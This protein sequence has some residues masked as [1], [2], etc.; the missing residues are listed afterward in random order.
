MEWT[1]PIEMPGVWL[2]A[3]VGLFARHAPPAI[4]ARPPSTRCP[5]APIAAV[6]SV[7]DVAPTGSL[8]LTRKAVRP[9]ERCGWPGCRKTRASFTTPSAFN[10]HAMGHA[11]PFACKKCGKRF[12]QRTHRDRHVDR[13]AV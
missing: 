1:C 2:G 12:A 3:P 8:V 13:H 10:R 7:H 5:L 11:K 6:T 4:V 9:A